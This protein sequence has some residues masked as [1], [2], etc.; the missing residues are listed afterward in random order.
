MA[1]N[2]EPK[3]G[4]KRGSGGGPPRRETGKGKIPPRYVRSDD[5]ATADPHTDENLD[6]GLD[7][8]FPA[9]DPVSISPGAD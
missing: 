1:Q 3:R 9:S 7:E 5:A 6:H 8:T 2:T 4:P